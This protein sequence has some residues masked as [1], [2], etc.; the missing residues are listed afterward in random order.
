MTIY[1]YLAAPFNYVVTDSR[2]REKKR[3]QLND[4]AEAGSIKGRGQ[5]IG[6]IPGQYVNCRSVALPTNNKKKIEA[7]L[8]NALEETF[9][10]DIDDLFFRLIG[11]TN[12]P[13]KQALV[14]DRGQIKSLVNALA[15]AKFRLDQMVP[16]FAF[17]PDHANAD[18]GAIFDGSGYV[19]LRQGPFDRK[20]IRQPL[21]G[22]WLESTPPSKD[23][24]IAQL[25]DQRIQ[26]IACNEEGALR[27]LGLS[28][29][30]NILPW[31]SGQSW[32]DWIEKNHRNL[33]QFNLLQGEY[34]PSHRARNYGGLKFSLLVCLVAA[35]LKIAS[36]GY[37]YLGLINE[38]ARLD[39]DIKTLFSD[40]FPDVKRIVNPKVQMRNKIAE[41]QNTGQD[42][43]DFLALLSLV[44]PV[45][46]QQR[47]EFESI[48][49]RQDELVFTCL[50]SNFSALNR[51]HQ[52]L[53]TLAGLEIRLD[54]SGSLN[55]KTSGRF[56]A[57]KQ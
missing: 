29:D 12:Q 55:G 36:D 38:N 31:S 39:Q 51:F 8:P 28:S 6:V 7:I 56:I 13:T 53:Q 17:M 57:V 23:Q 37:H 40:T 25:L 19:Y 16:D 18:Y 26:T 46:A 22:L 10:G 5:K 11:P 42:Q 9:V 1:L 50:F 3:G 20:K 2:G 52:Q 30:A 34:T 32:P 15:A 54:S 48:D 45:A 24:S 4:L 35:L 49:F 44:A 21:I 33:P 27:R 14:V 47:L 41:L 43:D